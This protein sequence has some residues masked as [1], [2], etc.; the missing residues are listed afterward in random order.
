V[1]SFAVMPRQY[2]FP[3]FHPTFQKGRKQLFSHD[4]EPWPTAIEP[5]EL[6]SDDELIEWESSVGD[7][8]TDVPITP[9]VF[10]K[11][12]Q[13][14]RVK[15]LKSNVC[16]A[17][18]DPSMPRSNEIINLGLAQDDGFIA[19][20]DCNVVSNKS[21]AP[22]VYYA[23]VDGHI[24]SVARGWSHNGSVVK[25][26]VQA[27]THDVIGRLMFT[28]PASGRVLSKFLTRSYTLRKAVLRFDGYRTVSLQ[29]VSAQGHAYPMRVGVLILST[30]TCD[31]PCVNGK[32]LTLEHKDR[33]DNDSID[34]IC[35]LSRSEQN[36]I[37]NRPRAR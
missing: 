26:N 11:L 12:K 32:Y 31:R 9:L 14:G 34:A 5:Q 30:F 16:D 19:W 1:F 6:A 4:G 21:F 22:I 27:G 24:I 28:R 3:T 20:S 13:L 33:K 29:D 37:A 35:W 18:K 7:P 25:A 2:Q 8:N 15:M 23:H 10:R 36:M 17:N